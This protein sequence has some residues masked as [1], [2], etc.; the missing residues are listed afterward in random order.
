MQQNIMCSDVVLE[1]MNKRHFL[2]WETSIFLRQAYI[3]VYY[4]VHTHAPNPQI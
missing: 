4:F 1:A 2:K 3:S